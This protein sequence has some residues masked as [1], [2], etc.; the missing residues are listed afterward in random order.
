MFG[1]DAPF[2]SPLEPLWVGFTTEEVDILKGNRNLM[3]LVL[4]VFVAIMFLFAWF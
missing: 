2:T 4:P 3:W 1:T